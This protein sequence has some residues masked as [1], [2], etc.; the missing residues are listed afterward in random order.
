MQ[1]CGWGKKST[2]SYVSESNVSTD[3]W[4]RIQPPVDFVPWIKLCHGFL[5]MSAFL[6][7]DETCFSHDL[8]SHYHL[9]RMDVDE[10]T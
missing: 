5:S 7:V 10:S 9:E 6:G 8:H 2:P 1:K 4:L 3:S